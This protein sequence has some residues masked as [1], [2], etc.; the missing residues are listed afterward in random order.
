[1]HYTLPLRIKYFISVTPEVEGIRLILNHTGTGIMYFAPFH[2]TDSIPSFRDVFPGLQ[3]WFG[4]FMIPENDGVITVVKDSNRN[5]FF[6]FLF[7]V[8]LPHP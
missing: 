2:R 8:L 4:H 6:D 1:M 3:W 5:L 7:P